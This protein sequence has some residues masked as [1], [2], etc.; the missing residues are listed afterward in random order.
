[1][2]TGDRR[3]FEFRPGNDL[4][5]F[6][7]DPI[8]CATLDIYEDL[9][10]E[11][12]MIFSVLLVD[13]FPFYFLDRDN[14]RTDFIVH[15]PGGMSTPKEGRLSDGCLITMTIINSLLPYSGKFSWGANFCYFRG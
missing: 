7:G 6:D 5:R 3:N 13:V 11:G 4:A 2:P 1:M 12:D 8:A 9:D 15:D 10:Y 14:I